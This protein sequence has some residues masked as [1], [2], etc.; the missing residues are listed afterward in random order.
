MVLQ[1]LQPFSFSL[2]CKLPAVW[3]DGSVQVYD[4]V[5]LRLMQRQCK[6]SNGMHFDK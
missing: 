6:I 4:A 5:T 2:D 3:I 1:Y